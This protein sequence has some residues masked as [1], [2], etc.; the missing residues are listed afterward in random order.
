MKTDRN[1]ILMRLFFLP[2]KT[3]STFPPKKEELHESKKNRIPVFVL[4]LCILASVLIPVSLADAPYTEI[5]ASDVLGPYNNSAVH[6][7]D[8]PELSGY[9]FFGKLEVNEGTGNW[10][11]DAIAGITWTPSQIE[12][13]VTLTFGP[14]FTAAVDA[15]VV[16][17]GTQYKIYMYDPALASYQT[18]TADTSDMLTNGGQ[19][20]D[21]SHISFLRKR[22][23][24]SLS[25]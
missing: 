13:S 9:T 10:E 24:F 21:I 22:E 17:A 23:H 6:G 7:N 2:K 1:V 18:A 14:E 11:D 4:V 3:P 20:P 25:F 15:I 5:T 12:K 8:I 16:K 19:Q